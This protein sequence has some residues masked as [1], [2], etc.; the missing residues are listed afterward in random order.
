M[1]FFCLV[2]LAYNL[3]ADVLVVL[4]VEVSSETVFFLFC[5]VLIK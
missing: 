2:S 5:F 4:V 3:Y 1:V